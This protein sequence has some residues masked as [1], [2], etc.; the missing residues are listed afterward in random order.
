[1]RQVTERIS[2]GWRMRIDR[3]P[4]RTIMSVSGEIDLSN[5]SRLTDWLAII[6]NEQPAAVDID[7]ARMT[8]MDST[9]IRSFVTARQLCD[10]KSLPFRLVHVQPNTRRLIEAIG[11]AG[12]FN[13]DPTP[14]A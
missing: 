7:L 8:F 1:M 11:L 14:P 2:D 10:E 9:G 3:R 12:Y 5:A 4:E 6:I 13:L